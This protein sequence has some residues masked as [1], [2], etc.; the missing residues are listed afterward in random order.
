MGAPTG[1]RSLQIAALTSGGL[2]V[3]KLSLGLASGSLAVLASA[4]DSFADAL[5]SGVNAWGYA[6]AR[7]PADAEHPWGHGKFEGALAVAQGTL[8]LG[9]VVSLGVGAGVALVEGRA[10]PAVPLAV[11]ALVGS[12]LCAAFLTRLLARA[13]REGGSVVLAS[14]AAHYKTDLLA[15]LAAI[16]GLI[17]VELTGRAWLDPVAS[18]L[19]IGLMAREALAVVRGGLGELL[20]EALPAEEVALVQAALERHRARVIGFHGLRTRRSGP[21]RFVEVHAAFDP[22]L[23][24][25][26]VHQVVVEIGREV[27]TALP[28]SRVLVHPDAHGLPDPVDELVPAPTAAEGRSQEVR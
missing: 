17:G 22:H 1:L 18:L 4:G 24:L 2:A 15:A 5:M 20:D 3:T 7:A 6:H 27:R 9:I 21:H 16:V 10:A 26:A 28:G 14:D 11:G 8:L 19:L 25:A 12:G 13:A 23:T